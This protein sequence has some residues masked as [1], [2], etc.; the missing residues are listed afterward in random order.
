[1]KPKPTVILIRHGQSTFNAAYEATCIDPMMFDAP[2]SPLGVEQV[3]RTRVKVASLP[4]PDVIVTS[5]LTRALQTASGIFGGAGIPITVSALHREHL[6]NSCDV[7]RSPHFLAKEFP[8]MHFSHLADTWWY[9]GARD[10]RGIAVEPKDVFHKR[11]EDF[12]KWLRSHN[13]S[14]VAVVGHG[15]FF[16][17]LTGHRLQ[18]CEVLNWQL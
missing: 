14:M 1:V 17:A 11:V 8:Q 18:N 10:E 4:I 16:H 9:E 2:L 3:E 15:D 12:D 6:A 7:G 13:A 5:P